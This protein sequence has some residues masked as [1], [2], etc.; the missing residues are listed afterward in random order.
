[1]GFLT[2]PQSLIHCIYASAAT[3]PMHTIELTELLVR[4][5]ERN[6]QRGITG[7]LLHADDSFFQVV[8]GPTD[9]ADKLFIEIAKDPRHQ[10]VTLVIREPIAKRVFGDWTM[11]FYAV[12]G[13]E[14]RGI[15]GVNDFFGQPRA[16]TGI[17]A[18]RARKLLAAFREG[19]WRTRVHH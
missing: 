4:A 19:R 14:L 17:D 15:E 6:A 12:S 3:R 9:T 18:G 5:R 13:D 2:M 7:M 8:E 11:G 1:M 10:Q 16:L